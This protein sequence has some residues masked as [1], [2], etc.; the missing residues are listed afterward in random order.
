MKIIASVAQVGTVQY[1]F[2]RTLNK[3][4][5]YV[6]EAHIEG[7]QLIVFPE[8]FIGG[9][10]K[11]ES[12]GTVVGIRSAEGRERFK[13]YYNA[14]IELPSPESDQIAAIA[15]GF[16][17]YIISG[18]VERDGGTL[19]CSVGFFSPLEGLV[20][21]RRKLMPTGTERLIW[22]FGDETTLS[23][24]SHSFQPRDEDSPPS[25]R[26]SKPTVLSAAVCWENMMPLLRCHFYAQNVQIYTAPT[27]D[28]RETWTSTMVHIAQEGRCFVLGACQV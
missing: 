6:E 12:F 17:I 20:Y 23:T 16:N 15:R 4:R 1:D 28:A 19:Y 24:V 27:V 3:L 7:S 8:A 2:D 22:G 10:P 21:K 13:N 25:T 9:Y 18:I 14:A 11:Y 26:T 5:A